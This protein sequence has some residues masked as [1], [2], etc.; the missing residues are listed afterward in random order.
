MDCRKPATQQLPNMHPRMTGH[1]TAAAK[2]SMERSSEADAG[3]ADGLGLELPRIL[4]VTLTTVAAS[5]IAEYAPASVDGLETGGLLLG[6]IETDRVVVHFAG[7]PGPVALREPSRFQR[8]LGH[9][10]VLA[11]AAWKLN[12]SIWLGEWH[13]HPNASAA[14][15]ATDMQTYQQHLT[16]PDLTL[17]SFLSLIAVAADW[18]SPHVFAWTINLADRT[19]DE[20]VA[21]A[22]I[23]VLTVTADTNVKDSL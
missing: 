19:T 12:R 21:V 20:Q 22:V 16:D 10:Q 5:S 15:S 1:D 18:T 14:P 23:T 11:E 2:S 17:P 7:G 4:P 9:A 13:T 8:D 6:H 3:Q